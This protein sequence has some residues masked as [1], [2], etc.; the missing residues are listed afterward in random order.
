MPIPDEWRRISHQHYILDENRVAVPVDLMTWAQW[1]ETADR[2]VGR[3]A[4]ED[5]VVVSTV[6]LGLDHSWGERGPRH[7]F[8]TMVFG[9]P[10]DQETERYATWAQ[11]EA[12]HAAMVRRIELTQRKKVNDG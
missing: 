1:Y 4:F 10:F 12:G 6:F 5:G 3:E 11:A 9:G 8:E 7:I 2:R